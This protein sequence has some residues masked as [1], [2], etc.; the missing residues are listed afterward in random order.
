VQCG[1]NGL[2]AS[3]AG[4]PS[5]VIP[6]R[7]GVGIPVSV[8]VVGVWGE[9]WHFLGIARAMETVLQRRRETAW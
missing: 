2:I 7:E 4:C 1:R 8:E 5:I 3:F 9:D 6:M